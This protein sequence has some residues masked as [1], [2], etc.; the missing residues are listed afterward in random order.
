MCVCERK[1]TSS[2]VSAFTQVMCV[3]SVVTSVP[4]SV[5]GRVGAI[6]IGGGDCGGRRGKG[7]REVAT[8]VRGRFRGGSDGSCKLL[9]LKLAPLSSLAGGQES[10]CGFSLITELPRAIGQVHQDR[11]RVIHWRDSVPCARHH[12]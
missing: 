2:E 6:E 10:A 12:P 4:M 9:A 11:C 5:P 3:P 7:G 1:R 8:K